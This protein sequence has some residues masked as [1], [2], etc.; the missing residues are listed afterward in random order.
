MLDFYYVQLPVDVND[1]YLQP[2]EY[3]LSQ[4]YPNPFNPTTSFNYSLPSD[5]KVMIKI[6]DALGREVKT[7]VDEF[8]HSGKYTVYFNSTG[9]ASG[10]YIYKLVS[11]NYNT[12][13][14]MILMK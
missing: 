10:V 6:Y 9:L 12:V 13:K 3:S 7:L 14:K 8:K 4:N 1:N 11:G 5:G 2:L